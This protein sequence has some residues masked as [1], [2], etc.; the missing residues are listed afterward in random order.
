MR[1]YLFVLTQIIIFNA[2]SDTFTMTVNAPY[3]DATFVV[4]D[5]GCPGDGSTSAYRNVNVTMTVKSGFR[6]DYRFNPF[7]LSDQI[8]THGNMIT[9]PSAGSTYTYSF[10]SYEIINGNK[11]VQAGIE[12][13]DNQG[14]GERKFYSYSDKRFRLGISPA[15]V[16]MSNTEICGNSPFHINTKDALGDFYCDCIDIDIKVGTAAPIDYSFS[17]LTNKIELEGIRNRIVG[18]SNETVTITTEGIRSVP[19]NSITVIS[20]PATSLSPSLSFLSTNGECASISL[21][22]SVCDYLSG[23]NVWWQRRTEDGDW[24]SFDKTK[25][26]GSDGS[27]N[28]DYEEQL[29]DNVFHRKYKVRFLVRNEA[30]TATEE[31][32]E[33]VTLYISR[34]NS[35]P[36]N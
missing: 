29:P 23:R 31:E 19:G 21:S 7:L 22:G 8:L 34:T 10:I 9:S 16:G 28:Y 2:W 11:S 14:G 3:V 36:S 32:S 35:F 20:N 13:I 26:I 27:L 18:G 12:E 6:S 4:T 1:N 17:C 33:E 15:Y 25:T 30:N 24:Y 5:V